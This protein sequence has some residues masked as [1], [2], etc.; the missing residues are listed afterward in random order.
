M[1]LSLKSRLKRV[2]D[3]LGV[4]PLHGVHLQCVCQW[5]WRGT[6]AEFEELMPLAECLGPYYNQILPSGYRCRCGE[7]LWCETCYENAARQ[8]VVPTD[9]F[10][11]SEQARYF[12]LLTHME[13]VSPRPP[14]ARNQ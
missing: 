9:L 3:A 2:A 13:L 14:R 6:D 7:K 12:E 8:I 5:T 1:A 11:P 10:T 4:C